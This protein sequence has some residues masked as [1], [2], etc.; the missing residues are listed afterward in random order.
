MDA[1]TVS[2][3][4]VREKEF[5][6]EEVVELLENLSGDV[7]DVLEDTSAIQSK[8]ISVPPCHPKAGEVY[9]FKPDSSRNTSK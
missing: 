6:P 4:C 3:F 2:P 8:V 9:I 5:T 7:E 1:R